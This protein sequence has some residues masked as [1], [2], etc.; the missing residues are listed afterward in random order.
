ML[1]NPKYDEEEPLTEQD[2]H[3]YVNMKGFVQGHDEWQQLNKLMRKER[4]YSLMKRYV[5]PYT[6]IP[7]IRRTCF[8]Y[9]DNLLGIGKW[10]NT[11]NIDAIGELNSKIADKRS[12]VLDCEYLAENFPSLVLTI[13]VA[14][15]ENLDCDYTIHIRYGN[16]SVVPPEIKK[17]RWFDERDI[18]KRMSPIVKQK[19]M[20]RLIRGYRYDKSCCLWSGSSGNVST[21][22]C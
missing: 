19:Y 22:Y 11:R 21:H 14:K 8:G 7:C 20:P 9:T 4:S 3:T 12:I 10:A 18:E 13:H 17:L 2:L 1:N 6:G 15:K 16:V 5:N